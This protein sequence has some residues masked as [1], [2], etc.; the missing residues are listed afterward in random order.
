MEGSRRHTL[1]GI[2]LVLVGSVLLFR[3]LLAPVA[4]WGASAVDQRPV[5]WQEQQQAQIEMRQA[6]LEAQ[7]ELELSKL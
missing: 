4:F 6:E 3:A 2:G 7:R 5:I 1:L